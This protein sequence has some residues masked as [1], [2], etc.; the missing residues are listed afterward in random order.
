MGKLDDHHIEELQ[1]AAQDGYTV[2]SE[3]VGICIGALDTRRVGFLDAA[4]ENLVMA[5]GPPLRCHDNA[6]THFEWNIMFNDGTIATVYDYNMVKPCYDVME[7]H[8]GGHTSGVVKLVEQAV[9]RA[10]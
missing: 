6:G 1:Q 4:Y 7:W 9:H 10:Q 2:H 8:V 5:F 3:N